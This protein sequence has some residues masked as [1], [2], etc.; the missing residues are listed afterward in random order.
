M[1]GTSKAHN[2]IFTNTL[3]EL[4]VKL[5]GKSCR[6][7]GSDFR[8]N[9]PK[10]TLYTYPDISVYCSESETLDAEDNTATNPTMI[11]EILS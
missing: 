8:V 9:I 10:N 11:I 5:K 1:V 6:P 2:E 4:I 7:Y 3:G